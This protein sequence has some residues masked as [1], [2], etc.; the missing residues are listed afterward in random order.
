VIKILKTYFFCLEVREFENI[1]IRYENEERIR[2]HESGLPITKSTLINDELK[3]TIENSLRNLIIDIRIVEL[4]T[5][6]FRFGKKFTYL[7]IEFNSELDEDVQ[8]FIQ[9][10]TKP[11]PHEE[12]LNFI[13]NVSDIIIVSYYM[14]DYCLNR[15]IEQYIELE[16]I[17]EIHSKDLEYD[18]NLSF[19]IIK[20]HPFIVELSSQYN[21]DFI[22]LIKS[23]IISYFNESFPRLLEGIPIRVIKFDF[24]SI[25]E[26]DKGISSEHLCNIL[27]EKVSKNIG[28][29]YD[30]YQIP[31]IEFRSHL[32]KVDIPIRYYDTKVLE[33]LE[34]F[35]RDLK[36][37]LFDHFANLFYWRLDVLTFEPQSNSN[38][39]RLELYQPF[40]Q[41]VLYPK[42]RLERQLQLLEDELTF[43]ISKVNQIKLK[44]E[45]R[46]KKYGK[47]ELEEKLRNITNESEFQDI[48]VDILNDLGFSDVTINCGR[49]GFDEF[50]K[51]IV[52]SH[53][54]K[55]QKQ[56]WDAIVVKTGKIDQPEGRE[57]R[58]DIKEIIQKG[59]EALDIPFED[60]KGNEY[61]ITRVYIATNEKFT[62]KA[63][64]SI[65]AKFEGRVFFIEKK[66]LLNLF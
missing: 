38:V 48:L 4:Y 55:F 40:I 50:G 31:L 59:L 10:S 62:V 7:I 34:F 26:M 60:E 46:I 23:S 25:F 42:K 12:L 2:L 57:L 65:R 5:V 30:S 51:D 32:L 61:S 8:K 54:N 9:I 3:Q 1:P 6:R 41:N 66:T 15:N 24:C 43:C 17:R 22:N 44:K 36:S 29:L 52:F 19:E 53:R 49:R 64:K 16:L 63:K 45:D 37:L 20:I 58:N 28:S 18:P 33:S 47:E 13:E 14:T 56:E 11:Q 39:K 21:L 27:L 35:F